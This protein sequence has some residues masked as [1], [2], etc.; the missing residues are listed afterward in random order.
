MDRKESYR[1][2]LFVDEIDLNCMGSEVQMVE[3]SK[4]KFAHYHK[5]K[6]EFFMFLSGTGTAIVDGKEIILKTGTRL[7]IKPGM[8]HAFVNNSE[9]P[10]KAIMF[11]TNSQVSDAF[12]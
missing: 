10:L 7:L 2:C 11:K 5:E 9:I 3:F 1:T 8:K 4:G 6:T 12:V